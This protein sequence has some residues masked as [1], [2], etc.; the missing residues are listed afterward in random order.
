MLGRVDGRVHEVRLYVYGQQGLFMA[1]DGH[2]P[3]RPELGRSSPRH[4]FLSVDRPDGAMYAPSVNQCHCMS[5][6][7]APGSTPRR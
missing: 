4:G 7:Y 3:A 1:L 2:R 6:D 5:S